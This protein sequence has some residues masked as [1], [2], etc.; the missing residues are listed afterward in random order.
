MHNENRLGELSNTI[1]HNY[2]NIIGISEE[3][4]VQESENLSEEVIVENFPNL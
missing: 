2:I 4:R 3:E 1:K